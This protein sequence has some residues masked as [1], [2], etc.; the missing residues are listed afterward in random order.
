MQETCISPRERLR[1]SWRTIAAICL[2][3]IPFVAD[4]AV[5]VYFL[6]HGETTWNRAKLLQGSI[7]HVD[8]TPKG[9]LMAEETAQGMIA[10]DIRFGRIYT[11]P[12]LR[13]RHTAAILAEGG[14]GP[15][16]VADA[17]LREMCLGWYEGKRYR[18]GEWPDDNLRRLFEDPEAFVP[19]GEGAETFQMVGVRLRDFLEHEIPPLDGKVDRVLC[20]AHSMA[21]RALVRE[22]AG[23]E[24]PP[25]ALKALQR[26]CCVHVVRYADGRFTLQETGKIFY[27]PEKFD[28]PAEPRT[29]AS[30]GDLPSVA[31]GTFVQRKVLA[32]VDVTLVSKGQFRFEKGRFFEW[33]TREPVASL[34]HATPTNY[35]FT[36]NGRTVVRELTVDVDSIKSLFAIKEMKEFVASIQTDPPSGFPRHVRVAF[37]N[38]DRLEIDISMCACAPSTR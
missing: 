7:D 13:A 9:I 10:A 29:D 12:Y 6:R 32:D 21:L 8:L 34:F 18:K 16:P 33:D 3:A 36:A 11:S 1:S 27:S 19:R 37:K 26:N 14:V 25:S 24:A 17:R 15:T 28:A 2:A 22:L 38:G 20:V 4:A 5:D 30:I 35:A 31:Q 23:A